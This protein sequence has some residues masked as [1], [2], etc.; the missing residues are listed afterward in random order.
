MRSVLRSLAISLLA[1]ALGLGP[2]PAAAPW[3]KGAVASDHELAS[4]AGL[5]MLEMG[6]NAVDAAVATSFCLSVVRPYASGIGGGGFLVLHL[7]GE[8]SAREV[9]LDYRERAPAAVG[10]ATFEMHPDTTASQV[11]GASV[12]IPGAAAGLLYALEHFGTLARTAVLGPAIRAAEEG[13]VADRHYVLSAR[14]MIPLFEAN[15]A[16]REA[17]P[18]TWKRFFAEGRIAEGDTIRL[19]EQAAALRLIAERGAAAFY[20]GPIG[21]AVVR[22][23]RASGGAFAPEDLARFEVVKRRPIEGTFR[24]KRLI[25]MPPPSSGGI[26]LLQILGIFERVLPPGEPT[27]RNGPEY[28]HLLAESM[29]HAFADRAEWLGDPAFVDVPVEALL[30]D[31]YLDER[32]ASVRPGRTLPREA[33]GTRAPSPDDKGTSAFSAVDRWGNAASGTESINYS[34]GSL[35]PVPEFGF[36]LNNTMDDFLTRPGRVNLFGLTQSDRNLPAPGKIPLSSMTPT[37]VL[38]ENGVFACAGGSGG[39]RIISAVAQVLLNAILFDLDAKSAVEEPRIH[40]QWMPNTLLLE[41]GLAHDLQKS[42]FGKGHSFART[43]AVAAVPF[44]RRAG[45]GYGAAADPR[46]GGAPAGY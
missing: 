3:T 29:K 46:K 23:A 6:G 24:G 43:E 41:P 26:A 34:F 13:F 9:A 4:R 36:L 25:G 45:E 17:Y 18:F 8:G 44:I 1:S 14:E 39:P 28:V 32:A 2:G 38:D 21:E 5:A 30:G 20:G 7:A 40:H 27:A 37:I 10:P 11:G 16:L 12:G 22:A 33:Y 42:L 31:A 15:P 35:V 19:P